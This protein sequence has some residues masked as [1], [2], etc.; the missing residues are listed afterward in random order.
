MANLLLLWGWALG[1]ST[2]C[3]YFSAHECDR[4]PAR[5]EP[6]SLRLPVIERDQEQTLRIERTKPWPKTGQTYVQ[7]E[8]PVIPNVAL[9]GGGGPYPISQDQP[10]VTLPVGGSRQCWPDQV[11]VRLYTTEP[12]RSLAD[13]VAA[14]QRSDYSQGMA[15]GQTSMRQPLFAALTGLPPLQP[16]TGTLVTLKSVFFTPDNNLELLWTFTDGGGMNPQTRI[17]TVSVGASPATLTMGISQPQ[18]GAM[19]WSDKDQWLAIQK[20]CTGKGQGLVL[21]GSCTPDPS[22]TISPYEVYWLAVDRAA[23]TALLRTVNPP[24]VLAVRS[25]DAGSEIPLSLQSWF[26]QQTSWPGLA[27][28]MVPAGLTVLDALTQGDISPRFLTWQSGQPLAASL[29]NATS[30]ALETDAALQ[31]AL[32]NLTGLT[33]LR[34]ADLDGDGRTD[35]LAAFT[36]TH[37]MANGLDAAL[38]AAAELRRRGRGDI[39]LVL[40]GD[41][42]L[43]PALM[44]RAQ[45]ESLGQHTPHL[46]DDA[47]GWHSGY[48]KTGSMMAA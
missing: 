16:P 24:W 39:K 4:D 29:W 14:N 3:S 27:D 9:S 5:C 45:R 25:K 15:T 31:K 44:E 47:L 48:L 38:N 32:Q 7:F 8:D 36:G 26:H 6:E 41:G 1:S 18:H 22:M 37:G 13:L 10:T 21:N 19:A 35:L 30:K 43:K 11:T 17:D 28:S 33:A 23:T 34:G 40:I 20:T 42:Q 2:G 12:G 46:L